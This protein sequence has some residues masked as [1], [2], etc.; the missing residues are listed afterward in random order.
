MNKPKF[1]TAKEVIDQIKPVSENVWVDWAEQCQV[2]RLNLETL[3]KLSK[4]LL[5]RHHYESRN[6]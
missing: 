6:L 2:P 3:N 4:L 5:E 1:K